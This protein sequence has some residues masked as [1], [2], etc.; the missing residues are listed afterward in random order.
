MPSKDFQFVLQ[1]YDHQRRALRKSCNATAFALFMEQRTGKSKVTLDTA[2]W[3]YHCGRIDCL[4]VI[5]PNGV[6]RNWITDEVPKHLHPNVNARTLLWRSNRPQTRTLEREIAE[7]LAH[8][9]LAVVAVN[10]E[11]IITPRAKALI[12]KLVDA[13]RCLTIVDESDCIKTPG[14]KR[15]PFLR[16]ISRLSPYRRILTGT[17]A[18]EG[19]P[20]D[21]YNQLR[22]LDWQILGFSTATEFRNYYAEFEDK[23]NHSTG[24]AYRVVKAYRHLEE[25]TQRLEPHSFRV[26]R[27]EC[28]DLPPKTYQKRYV[29]LTAAQRQVYDDLRESYVT[30]LRGQ[31]YSVP[32]ALTRLLRLQQ[33]AS[34]YLPLPPTVAVCEACQGE[35]CDACD[36]GFT[37][38]AA[39]PQRIDGRNPRL[40]ALAAELDA[41]GDE[42]TVIWARFRHDLDDVCGLLRSRGDSFARYDGTVTGRARA[43]GLTA[44]QAG[45]RRHLVGQAAAGGRGLDMSAATT[46][47]YYSH[48]H[49]LLLRLQSEDRM[50]SG[51]DPRPKSV[52]DLVAEDTVDDKMLAAFREKKSLADLITGDD[53]AAWL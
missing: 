11:A 29:Q 48:E 3:L 8:R 53:P 30:E 4:L 35:G 45:Q 25:M 13:R 32:H 23:V 5:A 34:N 47:I 51:S 12:R 19:N 38:T 43:D 33:V 41:L 40:E 24:Q 37:I 52:I 9:G 22:F 6:H 36:G 1:P 10:V 28:F 15:A 46:T 27:A 20:F 44:F 16:T 17:P 2:A 50:V 39:E 14:A 21:L 18:P 49:R 42:R 26:T 7:I 31:P